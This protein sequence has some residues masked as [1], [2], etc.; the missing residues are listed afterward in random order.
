[1]TNIYDSLVISTVDSI[2]KIF[3]ILQIVLVYEK[4]QSLTRIRGVN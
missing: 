1:M 2:C 4:F 3:T